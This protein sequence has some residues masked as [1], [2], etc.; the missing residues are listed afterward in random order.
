MEQLKRLR[1][2]RNLS[3]TKLAQLADLNP[4]TV[5]QIEKGAREASTATLRKL[6]DALD[7]SLVELLRD[8]SPKEQAPLSHEDEEQRR[9][10]YL[11]AWRMHVDQVA[12]RWRGKLEK[13]NRTSSEIQWETDGPPVEGRMPLAYGWASEVSAMANDLAESILETLQEAISRFTLHER[14]EALE[15][16]G[17]LRRLGDIADQISDRAHR[18]ILDLV[19]GRHDTRNEEPETGEL[20]RARERAAQRNRL[21]N[22]VEAALAA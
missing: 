18:E 11:R 6:A 7:V 16:L 14:R 8:D 13:H 20:E 22:A 4:A 21:L 15:L 3:Q 5:N 2:E 17:A 1:T 9:L 19:K 12:D 10:H